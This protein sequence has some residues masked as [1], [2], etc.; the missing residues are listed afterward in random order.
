MSATFDG[1]TMLGLGLANI[2]GNE[3]MTEDT[4]SLE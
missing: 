2:V 1:P 4:A 3:G